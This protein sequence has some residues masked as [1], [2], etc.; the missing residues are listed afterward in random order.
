MMINSGWQFTA[1]KLK[2]FWRDIAYVSDIEEA[3]RAIGAVK[4]E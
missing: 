1:Y 4:T 3:R 2:G